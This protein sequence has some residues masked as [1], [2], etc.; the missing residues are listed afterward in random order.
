MRSLKN[1]VVVITGAGQGIGAAI[2]QHMSAE[3]AIVVLAGRTEKKL[4][5]VAESLKIREDRFLIV[6]ADVTIRS[7]MKKIITSTIKKFRRIDIFI[8]NAGVGI[9][10]PLVETTEREFNIIFNTNLKAVYYSF[11][12]LIPI[13]RKAGG[14]QIINISSLAGRMGVA[15]LAAYSSS[16]AALNVFSEAVAGEVRNENIKICVL[17]PASTDTRFMSNLSG[18]SKSPSKAA[19]KLT[20]DEVAEA[21]VFLAR[22]NKNAWTSIADIRPLSVKK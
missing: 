10:K 11:L 14:G 7:R 3:G 2:A 9:H 20:V 15:G 17:S 5:K 12:E 1:L 4:N 21:V 16:K 18:K 13:L 19:Q 22:Q 6:T 8:N